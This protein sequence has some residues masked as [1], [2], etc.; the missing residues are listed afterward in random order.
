[1]DGNIEQ[2]EFKFNPKYYDKLFEMM[3]LKYGPHKKITKKIVQNNFGNKFEKL[4]ALWK[5]GSCSFTLTNLAGK[6]DE[7]EIYFG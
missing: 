6:I 7:G 4:S 1:M 2:I 3:T 5:I